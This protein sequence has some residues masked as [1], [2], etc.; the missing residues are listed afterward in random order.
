MMDDTSEVAS[1]VPDR[2]MPK[3]STTGASVDAPQARLE[4]GIVGKTQSPNSLH[5]HDVVK[6]AGNSVVAQKV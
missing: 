3:T 4:L 5:T 2:D 6:V 1:D